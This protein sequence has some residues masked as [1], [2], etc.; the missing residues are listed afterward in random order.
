[1]L[2][3]R[4]NIFEQISIERERQDKLH[5]NFLDISRMDVL[6]E[7]V[8]EVAKAKNEQDKVGMRRELIE[9]AAVCVR[10]VETMD[11]SSIFNNG[12]L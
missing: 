8:G 6:I 2:E 12:N 10:W 3:Q 4:N 7:E 5:P 1:M 9:V 11:D